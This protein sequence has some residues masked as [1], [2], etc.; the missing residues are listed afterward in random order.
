MNRSA[1]I[2]TVAPT[3]VV[4]FVIF[5]FWHR[6]RWTVVEVVG[7]ILLIGGAVFMTAAR[8]QLGNSFSIRPEARELVTHGIYSK[9]RNPVYVS[10]MI[11]IAGMILCVNRPQL[12]W[13]FAIVIPLQV[14]R[15]RAESK[16]LEEHFGDAYRRYRA[17]TWF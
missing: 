9:I 11:L 14:I 10:G 15:A 1:L 2:F 7:L 5:N 6:Q 16:V 13:I 8:I 12:L 4:A 3:I 17:R